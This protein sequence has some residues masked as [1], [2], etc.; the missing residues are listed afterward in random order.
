VVAPHWPSYSGVVRPKGLGLNLSAV[1]SAVGTLDTTSVFNPDDP[2]QSIQGQATAQFDGLV[3]S[4]QPVAALQQQV[5]GAINSATGAAKTAMQG[6]AGELQ[7]VANYPGASEAAAGMLT[8]ANGGTPT[9]TQIAGGLT[10]AATVG[11]VALG[12]TAAT[13]AAVVAPICAVVWGAGYAIGAF[14]QNI[15][16]ITNSGPAAC[17]PQDTDKRGVDPSDLNWHSYMGYAGPEIGQ[18]WGP[19][20]PT[21]A[22]SVQAAR[23]IAGGATGAPV[24]WPYWMPYTRGAFENWARPL[25]IHAEE[26]WMNCKMVPPDNTATTLLKGLVGA[27]N[28]QNAGAPKRTLNIAGLGP[29]P[30]DGQITA[31]SNTS[32]PTSFRPPLYWQLQAW[33]ADPIQTLLGQVSDEQGGNIAITIADPAPTPGGAGGGAAA[34]TSTST[35][36]KV[37]VGTLVVG[38]A[39]LTGTA[40]YAF[41]KGQAL[42]TVLQAGW[43]GLKGWFVR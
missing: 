32:F 27:W 4:A 22:S 3:N 10:V 20:A 33:Q 25:I 5:Q 30:L 29:T 8:A 41:A 39:A 24:N 43:T 18:P 9:Q 36:A 19:Y 37:A 16:G 15:F 26:L 42:S 31:L 13:A 7:Q 38:G 11:A 23:A 12:A 35:A 6:Y 14:V 2:T 34:A 40:V 17:S 28:A 21:Q 1:T